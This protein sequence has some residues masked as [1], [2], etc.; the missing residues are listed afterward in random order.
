MRLSEAWS[1][2]K[3][4]SLVPGSSGMVE[5]DSSSASF[6]LGSVS[7]VDTSKNGKISFPYLGIDSY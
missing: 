2:D 7:C 5:A 3:P 6:G 1:P 4:V